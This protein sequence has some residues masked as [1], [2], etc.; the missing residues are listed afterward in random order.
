MKIL[1]IKVFYIFNIFIFSIKKKKLKICNK[2]FIERK[3][4]Q[5]VI[6]I[7]LYNEFHKMYRYIF[8]IFN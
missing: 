2:I 4:L 7:I 1:K 8:I 3:Q 5:K 6:L